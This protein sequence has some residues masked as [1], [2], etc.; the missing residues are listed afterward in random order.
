MWEQRREKSDGG[1][2]LMGHEARNIPLS[3]TPLVLR[4][5][6]HCAVIQGN[7]LAWSII[8]LWSQEMMN[9]FLQAR[10]GLSPTDWR[11]NRPLNLTSLYFEIINV[12]IKRFLLSSAYSK[13]VWDRTSSTRRQD[14]ALARCLMLIADRSTPRPDGQP[15]PRSPS[16]QTRFGCSAICASP[17]LLLTGI[18]SKQ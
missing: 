15:C 2:Q 18:D 16:R 17:A 7:V 1:M 3:P 14:L 9:A 5:R 13:A 10:H 6:I 11:E 8:S 4:H 12:Q